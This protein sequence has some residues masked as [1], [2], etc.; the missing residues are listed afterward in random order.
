MVHLTAENLPSFGVVRIG[1]VFTPGEHRGRGIA[2]HVVGE[3]TRRGLEAGHRLCLFTD[4][5]NPTSNKIYEAVG[6][7]PVTDMAE[8]V[9][10]V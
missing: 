3:L 7:R 6:Y 5:A 2:S 9:I 1:P 4:Q 8:H 10:E